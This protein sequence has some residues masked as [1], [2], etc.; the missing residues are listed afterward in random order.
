MK[1]TYLGHSCFLLETRAGTR[2]LIDPYDD[3]VGYPVPRVAADVVVLTHEHGDHA[4]VEMATGS[5][6]VVR[7]LKEGGQEH[8]RVA[9][10][11][12]GVK[13]STVHTYHDENKGAQR[14]RN[15]MVLFEADDVKVL[16]AGDL[17][18]DLDDAAVKAAAGADVLMIPV[19][20]HYTIDAKMAD[21]VIGRLRPRAV[22]PMHFKTEVNAGWPISTI[23]AFLAGK[24]HVKRVGHGVE[25]KDLPAQPEV[26]VMDWKG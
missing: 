25:V 19:G 11:V 5:P 7:G 22:I 9:E 4:Y 17:G 14:G 1:I 2:V 24:T 6:K 18:H 15:A 12:K 10:T 8:A 26:W 23:D 21:V 20:G 16:H 13:M 3:K